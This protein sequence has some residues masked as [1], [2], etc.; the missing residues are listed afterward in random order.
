MKLIYVAGRYRSST[1]EGVELNIQAATHIGVIASEKG[2]YPV[3]PHT[4]TQHFERLTDKP[5][6]FYLDGTLELMYRCDAVVMVPGWCTSE[7]AINE[8][9]EALERGMAVFECADNLVTVR[10]FEAELLRQANR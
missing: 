4:N 5:D 6:E 7:G 8:H 9:R 10:S 1:P 3:I 2:W